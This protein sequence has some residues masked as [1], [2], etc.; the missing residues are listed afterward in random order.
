VCVSVCLSHSHAGI[1]SERLNVGSSKQRL[2]IAQGFYSSQTPTVVGGRLLP[3]EI[4]AQS[5]SPPFEHHNFDQYPL[6]APQPWG[7]AK[8]SFIFALNEVGHALSKVQRSEIGFLRGRVSRPYN[9]IVFLTLWFRLVSVLFIVCY[10][11]PANKDY[12]NRCSGFSDWLV[13]RFNRAVSG[14]QG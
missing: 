13:G 14:V 2:V 11:F 8:K 3:P 12:Q 6:I 5:D 1:V 9:K 4:C 7:L 10:R